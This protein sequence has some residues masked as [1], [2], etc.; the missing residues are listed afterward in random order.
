MRYDFGSD[1]TAGMAPA[2]L[3]ALIAANEGHARAYGADE[4]TARA[5]DLIRARL[6]ADAEVRFVFSGTAANAIALSMLAWPHEAVLAHHAAH[7]CTDETGAPGFF[8]SG[9]GLLGLPGLS[10]KI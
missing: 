4:V 6:D 8:G 3:E 7:V 10:G 1:N 9:V 5:A 2:A